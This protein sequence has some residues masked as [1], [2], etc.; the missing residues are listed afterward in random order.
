M[1]KVIGKKILVK[2]DK[3]NSGGLRI[4]PA[5]DKDGKGN[6]GTILGVGGVW[7]WLIG[8]RKGKHVYF[9]KHYITNDGF[10]DEMVFVNLEDILAVE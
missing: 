5:N 7:L 8:V 4:T 9:K 1:I 2:K 10:E 6:S 3:I